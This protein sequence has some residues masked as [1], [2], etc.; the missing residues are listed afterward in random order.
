[1]IFPCGHSICRTHTQTSL[2]DSIRCGDCGI[3]HQIP[4]E[5][6]F[7]ENKS[8][9]VIISTQIHRIH[10]DEAHEI[11]RADCKSPKSL[12]SQVNSILADPRYETR[13]EIDDM[14]NEIAKYLLNY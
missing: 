10:L 7:P 2:F 12:I 13:K 8:L 1:M 4:K 14:R 5:V 9:A 3:E 6:G 11:A